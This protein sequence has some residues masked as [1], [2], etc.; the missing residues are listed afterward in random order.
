M[1][2][3]V[4]CVWSLYCVF[5]LPSAYY[6]SLEFFLFIL[7]FSSFCNHSL[8]WN[9]ERRG[10]LLFSSPYIFNHDARFFYCVV[11]CTAPAMSTSWPRFSWFVL[12]WSGNK[13][14]TTYYE[15]LYYTAITKSVAAFFINV[16]I[17]YELELNESAHVFKWYFLTVFFKTK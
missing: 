5:Y 7:L 1:S 12:K 4:T 13:K 14:N 15:L 9:A 3:L 8:V 6:T 16:W 2:I 11:N 17:T 10:N